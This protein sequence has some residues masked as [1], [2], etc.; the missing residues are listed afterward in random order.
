MHVAHDAA[1]L[2]VVSLAADHVA[3]TGVGHGQFSLAF[4]Q[5]VGQQGVEA[6]GGFE[7]GEIALHKG[8]GQ[9]QQEHRRGV[10]HEAAGVEAEMLAER[11]EH[12]ADGADGQQGRLQPAGLLPRGEMPEQPRG[13]HDAER[14]RGPGPD[15]RR[16]VVA[17]GHRTDRRPKGAEGN[18]DQEGGGQGRLQP[19]QGSVGPG[20]DQADQRHGD[21]T[22]DRE[23]EPDP[24]E[25]AEGRVQHEAIEGEGA[26]G[27]AQYGQPEGEPPLLGP[28]GEHRGEQADQECRPAG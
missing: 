18:E 4:G 20:V 9:G 13:R 28:E 15:D 2:V 7:Q 16:D 12:D 3:L 27:T 25:A 10:D 26:P 6:D 5:P 24:D 23:E 8:G 14:G 22:V 21:Q 17:L 1:A 19:R 11:V